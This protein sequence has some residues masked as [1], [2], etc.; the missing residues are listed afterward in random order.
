MAS[1]QL[2]LRRARSRPKRPPAA[3]SRAAAPSSTSRDLN[4]YY[5]AKRALEYITLGIQPE[6]GHRV[7][8]A[9]GLRQEHVPAHAEPDERHHP[10]HAGRGPGPHRRR[11]H[12]RP[13]QRRRSRSGGA[14]AWCSRSPTRFRSRSS[15]TWPT[16]CGS[17]A[18]PAIA[19]RST[20]GSKTASGRR[21]SGT[22]SRTGCTNRRSRSRAAS[23]SGSAS[24]ARWRS[25][26][27]SC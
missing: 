14:S 3:G 13:G 4:F 8:R 23:S 5:G 6:P 2:A 11:G 19:R 27:R 17:T 20:R 21:R 25:S 10:G 7:H 1:A 22:R 16:A 15:R 12:L 26:R 24:R 18:W 9:V